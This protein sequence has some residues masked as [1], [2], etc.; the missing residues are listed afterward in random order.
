M[1]SVSLTTAD[2]ENMSTFGQGNSA[3]STGIRANNSL[4]SNY[5]GGPD[6][7]EM[8]PAA[9]LKQPQTFG[10]AGATTDAGAGPNTVG[11]AGSTGSFGFGDLRDTKRPR[12][13]SGGGG[14]RGGGSAGGAA[15]TPLP[16]VDEIG[17]QPAKPP[18]DKN[19][20]TPVTVV[21]KSTPGPGGRNSNFGYGGWEGAPAGGAGS[22][23]TNSYGSSVPGSY[24]DADD[25]TIT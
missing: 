9:G 19:K 16:D 5:D 2:G 4:F 12:K 24:T 22:S 13:P 23:A 7:N 14:G 20:P 21:G 1:G 25:D 3:Y 15:T 18:V 11:Q 17:L 10:S 6:A 8:A